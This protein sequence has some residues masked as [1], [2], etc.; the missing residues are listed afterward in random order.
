[1]SGSLWYTYIILYYIAALQRRSAST[2]RMKGNAMV[3]IIY[4]SQTGHARRYAEL[5]AKR[6]GAEALSLK[7]AKKSVAKGSGVVFIGWVFANQIRG[8]SAACRRWDVK[9]VCAVGM[10][11]ECEANTAALTE[12]NKP[13]CPMFYLRGGLD[14]SKLTGLRR[15]LLCLV[16]DDLVREGKPENKELAEILTTGA[17]FVSEEALSQIAALCLTL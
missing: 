3:P 12:K 13:Q 5:L 9:A 7:Q 1:M 2:E 4:E 8:F 14:P 11:P 15:K 16:R 6:L 10:F 17:D